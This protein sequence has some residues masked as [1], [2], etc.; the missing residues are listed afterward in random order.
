MKNKKNIL[1]LLLIF[2]VALPK[3]AFSKE[4][5]SKFAINSYTVAPTLI[6]LD[7][8]KSRAGI[9]ILTNNTK[10]SYKIKVDCMY[11]KPND[12]FIGEHL[13]K[14]TESIEDI[15][16]LIIISPKVVNLRPMSKRKIRYSLRPDGKKRP[17]G[18]YRASFDFMPVINKFAKK[19][20]ENKEGVSTQIN[21]L[22]E[23]RLPLYV[24]IGEKKSAKLDVK[25][26]T[27]TADK[28]KSVRL[29]MINKSKWRY[30]AEFTF[31]D[32]STGEKI[33]RVAAV[34]LR[35]T[36]FSKDVKLDKDPKGK[37][38]VIKWNSYLETS[39]CEPGELTI[40]Y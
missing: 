19:K 6:E 3:L 32:K 30:P 25:A 5:Y 39:P 14:E 31:F 40:D 11:F 20:D 34:M 22:L 13:T 1:L 24:N 2:I 4:V 9:I 28:G 8:Q 16:K 29:H 36:K 18:E 21:W 33:G 7:L 38:I 26:E 12:L 15:S 23:L 35:G 10:N 17:A 27:I 37:E